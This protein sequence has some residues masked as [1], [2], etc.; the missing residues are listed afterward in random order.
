MKGRWPASLDE[1]VPAHLSRVPIDPYDGRRLR[2]G[3]HADGVVVYAVW[4]DKQ[5]NGGAVSNNLNERPG[6][7]IGIRLWDVAK[8]RQPDR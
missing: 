6:A 8:R 4:T 7:D 2:F 3:R 1:L 5:D